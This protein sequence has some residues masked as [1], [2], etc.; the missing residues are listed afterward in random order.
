MTSG[1]CCAKGPT[2]SLE[3][4]TIKVAIVG[5]LCLLYRVGSLKSVQVLVH[6]ASNRQ[7]HVSYI[8]FT[9]TPELTTLLLLASGLTAIGATGRPIA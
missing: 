7:D 3:S 8:G 9:P 6:Q 2:L 5:L 4:F 1:Q